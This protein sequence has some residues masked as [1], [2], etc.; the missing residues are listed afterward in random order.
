MSQDRSF[1]SRHSRTTT[2]SWRDAIGTSLGIICRQARRCYGER[3]TG[4]YH[5]HATSRVL[6]M[7]CWERTDRCCEEA[8]PQTQ[9]GPRIADFI[10]LN[11][12]VA[13]LRKL[14]R[15]RLRP[16]RP[17]MPGLLSKRSTKKVTRRQEAS[18]RY[19]RALQAY[20]PYRSH[21]I[22]H[23]HR[24]HSPQSSAA[25]HRQ[26]TSLIPTRRP[27]HLRLTPPCLS[28]HPSI[29]QE[30]RRRV[31]LIPWS[32]ASARSTRH[33]DCKTIRRVAVV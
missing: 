23:L 6:R 2:F 18:I 7:R 26:P 16:P 13:A 31:S 21:R 20:R 4:E 5:R 14:L 32:R 30:P 3:M 25:T 29:S 17:H 8:D 22:H 12:L 1:D 11:T 33:D 15:S 27:S 24:L 19:E 10:H 9:R 28:S